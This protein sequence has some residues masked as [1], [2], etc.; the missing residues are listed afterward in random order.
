ME[1]Q[2]AVTIEAQPGGKAGNRPLAAL[3]ML[4]S[5]LAAALIV[6]HVCV[7]PSLADTPPSPTEQL[8]VTIEKVTE[9]LTDLT[10]DTKKNKDEPMARLCDTVHEGFSL[11]KTARLSLTDHWEQ[12]TEPEQK[13]FVALF[14]KLLETTYLTYADRYQGEQ[15][16]F[17]REATHQDRAQ[18]HVRVIHGILSIPV[19]VNM[20]LAG[21]RQWRVY[22]VVVF[23]ISLVGNYRAQFN[24]IIRRHSYD[25][26]IRIMEEKTAGHTICAG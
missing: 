13:R 16:V 7:P 14:G 24:H 23:G 12:R 4:C 8:K 6:C 15:V 17:I 20:H 25:E 3:T 2:I 9:I 22:D 1:K 26:V 21:D 19:T 18:V 5:W 10:A 11:A